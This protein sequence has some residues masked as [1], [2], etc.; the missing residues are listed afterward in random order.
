[1][2]VGMAWRMICV[3]GDV[4]DERRL[5]PADRRAME[6]VRATVMGEVE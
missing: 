4:G 2:W 5:M 3:M 6:R 1:M